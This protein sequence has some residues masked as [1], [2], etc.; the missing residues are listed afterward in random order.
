MNLSP[1]VSTSTTR[2]RHDRQTATISGG[3]ASIGITGA[4]TKAVRATGVEAGCT[5]KKLDAAAIEAAAQKAA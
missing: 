3:A 2:A 5:G 1:S 4:G